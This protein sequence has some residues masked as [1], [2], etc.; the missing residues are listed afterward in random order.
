MDIMEWRF[1]KCFI[2]GENLS[3][4]ES[5]LR[6]FGW[7]K[8][9]VRIITKSA[10]Y[11]IKLYVLTNATTASL[12]IQV[13]AHMVKATMEM[14]KNSTGYNCSSEKLSTQPSMYPRWPLLHVVGPNEGNGQIEFVCC[15]NGDEESVTRGRN[16][17]QIN[18]GIQWGG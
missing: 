2:P 7:I 16:N 12:Y 3:L 11:G 4:D 13:R 14:L 18:K 6:E 8:F 10:Q 17:K 9:K 1:N 5:L 15:E